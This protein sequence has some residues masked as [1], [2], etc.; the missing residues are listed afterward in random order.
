MIRS[1]SKRASHRHALAAIVASLAFA[2]GL[3]VEQLVAYPGADRTTAPIPAFA[4]KYRTS[5]ST[6][7]AA[8][9]KLNVLGEAFRLNGYEFPENDDL[10]R[11]EEAVPLGAEPWKDLWPRAIWPGELP[12]TPPL[13]L[14]IVT[15]AQVTSDP[16]EAFDWTLRFPNEIYALAGGHL[17]GGIGFF[18][19]TEWTPDEGV[20]VIQAKVLFQNPLPFLPDRSL[21]LWVGKQ[22]L[23]L[24]TF[25]DRQIDRAARQHLSWTEFAVSDLTL[26]DPTSGDSLRSLNELSFE[27]TQPAIEVNGLIGRRVFYAVGLA[28]G[29][30]DAATD[31]NNRK[32]LYY[33]LRLKLGGLALNGTY[34]R[35]GGPVVG[36]GGQLFDRAFVIEQF[37]YFGAAPVADG[38]QDEHRTL[39]VAGRWLSGPLDLG[40]GYIWG[41]NDNP[42]GLGRAVTATHWSAFTKGEFFI[43]PWLIGSVK[44]ERLEGHAREGAQQGLTGGDLEVT[45]VLPGV[46]ALVH[47]NVRLVVEG[48]LYGDYETGRVG[49]RPNSLW[50]RLDVTF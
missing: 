24:F 20:E 34:D 7:H 28:Q 31:D 14:R 35:G 43:F 11:K 33:K 49:G 19:E 16:A 22:N 17:G 8:A 39:G 37:G 40:I 42:W 15:D 27:S 9:P 12:G 36:T 25:A 26:R 10:L 38:L 45:R 5:C 47:Q 4:R 6:C 18:V 32:D 3:S 29:N 46:V 21:N 48:E 30:G 23:Y 41:E 1:A 44:L 13:S 50:F 2:L